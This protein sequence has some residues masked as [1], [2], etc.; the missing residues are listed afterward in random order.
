L[1]DE[2]IRPPTAIA[3]KQRIIASSLDVISVT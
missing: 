3:E 2:E 1:D